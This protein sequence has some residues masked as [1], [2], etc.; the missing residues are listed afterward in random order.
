MNHRFLVRNLSLVS[1]FF[2]IAL[3][4]APQS[5]N[6]RWKQ[7]FPDRIDWYVRS[8]TGILLVRSGKSLTAVDAMDGSRLW[9]L[10]DVQTTFSTNAVAGYSL[11]GKNMLEVPGMGILLLNRVRL[12]GN[13][14]GRLI[15]LNLMTGER[16]WDRAEI[17][18][19][20]TLTPIFKEGQ[21]VIASRKLQKRFLGGELMLPWG[22]GLPYNTY[23]FHFKFMC[24]DLFT[25]KT[26][27]STEYRHLMSPG[28]HSLQA[29]GDQLFLQS[30]EPAKLAVIR[31]DSTS[32][33][34][35]WEDSQRL[36]TSAVIPVPS[37]ASP[38]DPI[39]LKWYDGKLIYAA[40]NVYSM[41]P[42]TKQIKWWIGKFG[43]VTGLVIEDDFLV[44]LGKKELWQWIPKPDWK[45]GRG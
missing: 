42:E 26:L 34:I 30:V 5:L 44:A 9:T 1:A 43:K 3:Q 10:P 25:G 33:N 14:D 15:A 39:P 11:R 41:V 38:I 21:V 27:W 2:L 8:S 4:A 17:D 23:P 35:L 37:S 22:Y 7:H 16:L 31:I 36:Y 19:L 24:L 18:D 40:K 32:G 13:A 12:P 6:P 20:V 28:F 29:F 45:H